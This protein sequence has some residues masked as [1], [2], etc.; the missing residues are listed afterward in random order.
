MVRLNLSHELFRLDRNGKIFS[1]VDLSEGGFSLRI[2]DP[3]DLILFTLASEVTGTLNMDG[4]KVPVKAVV[5]HVRPDGVGCAFQGLDP[6]SAR[7]IGEF[8]DPATLG[9]ELRPVPTP[10]NRG[11]WYHGPSGTDLLLWRGVDGQFNRL[12]LLVF[13]TFVQWDSDEGL[14]TGVAAP[15]QVA[16]EV[17]GILRF[18]TLLM[19]RDEHP[20]SSKLEVAKR[21]VLSST[22]ESDLM[23]WCVRRL[24]ATPGNGGH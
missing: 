19:E 18:E 22:L 5:K 10:D 2:I 16:S 12:L 13:G 14:S 3:E 17:R 4:K 7:V 15:S 20:E 8:L 1:V 11:L 9:G 6:D 21:L 23:N 24:E